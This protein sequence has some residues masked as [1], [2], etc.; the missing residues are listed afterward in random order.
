[1]NP[2]LLK[3]TSDMESQVIVHGEVVGTMPAKEYFQYKK[4]LIPEIQAAYEKLGSQYDIIV[5]EGAGSPAEI[6]LKDHDIVNMG[7]A[8]LADAPVLL[9]GDIDRGGVFAQLIGTLQLL[10]EDEKERVK[11]LIINK[12]RGDLSIL[13]PGIHML[14]ERSEKAVVGVMP[15]LHLHLEDEDSVTSRFDK[16]SAALVDIA[17]I[18]FP[19]ISNFTDFTAFEQFDQVSLR[20][21]QYAE[22]LGQP[23]L[24]ILPGSKNTMADLEW[25]RQNGLEAA[26]KQKM[27]GCAIFGICGGYQMMGTLIDDPY[28]VEEGGSIR[29]MEL[30]PIETRMHQAKTRTQVNGQFAKVEGI[31]SVLTGKPV[32]GYEIHMGISTTTSGAVLCMITDTISGKQKMDGLSKGNC[33]GTYVHGIFD[34]IEIAAAIIKALAD[35]KGMSLDLTQVVEYQTFKEMQYDKLADAMREAFDMSFIYRLLELEKK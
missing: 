1:M 10:E 30:L 5:I 17:V 25:M 6:N 23:D 19:R 34:E 14:E 26:V 29:G 27:A 35:K 4:Q 32:A 8:K 24:I 15:Y 21:V 22:E 7:M 3:P 2:I 20:Y 13:K 31:F 18:R 16:R 12:F 33:Y 9:V 28:G 11:G